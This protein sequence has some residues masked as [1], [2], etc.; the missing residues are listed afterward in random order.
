MTRLW[1]KMN[2]QPTI[3]PF[4]VKRARVAICGLVGKAIAEPTTEVASIAR[5]D[6]QLA[7]CSTT[8]TAYR[9]APIHRSITRNLGILGRTR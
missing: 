1:I 7:I 2:M 3:E 4:L 8:M 9:K 6:A 5:M